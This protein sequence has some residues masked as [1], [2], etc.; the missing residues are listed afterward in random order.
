[1]KEKEKAIVTKRSGDKTVSVKLR[2]HKEH[3]VYSKIIRIDRNLQ[4]HDEYNL[5][6]PGDAVWITKCKPK[7]KTK[8][9]EAIFDIEP[10]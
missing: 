9:W 8:A 1:M 3:K 2:T 5:F 4:V 10:K 7:S 6:Q